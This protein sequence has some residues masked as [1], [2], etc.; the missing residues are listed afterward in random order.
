MRKEVVKMV[1]K[2]LE[3]PI[4][5]LWAAISARLWWDF[6]PPMVNIAPSPRRPDR[7]IVWSR[8]DF[9]IFRTLQPCTFFGALNRIGVTGNFA[10]FLRIPNATYYFW[11]ATFMIPVGLMEWV[12]FAG[13]GEPLPGNLES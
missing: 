4:K 9:I 3:P 7:R 6:Y 5:V 13:F 1:E 12:M 8:C 11:E 2:N 10:P